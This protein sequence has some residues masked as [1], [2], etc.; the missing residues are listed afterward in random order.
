MAYI[1]QA[2]NRLILISSTLLFIH[3]VYFVL[4]EEFAPSLSVYVCLKWIEESNILDYPIVTSSTKSQSWHH[5]GFL[6]KPTM[7][8]H[9]ALWVGLINLLAV[10]GLL[11]SSLYHLTKPMEKGWAAD[12]T[13]SFPWKSIFLS[14]RKEE[15]GGILAQTHSYF[16][17]F[18]H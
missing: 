1:W 11:I 6:P 13:L 17:F 18:C 2:N 3:F 9:R 12:S 16:F 8:S 15:G 5:E 10:R 7:R 4:Q 14:M